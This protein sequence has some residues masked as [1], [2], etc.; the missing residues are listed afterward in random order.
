[1]MATITDNGFDELPDAEVAERFVALIE[2]KRRESGMPEPPPA[3]PPAPPR[4]TRSTR[5]EGGAPA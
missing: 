1:M 5:T 4:R 3:P 2:R